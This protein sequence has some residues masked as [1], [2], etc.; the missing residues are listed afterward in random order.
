MTV[1]VENRRRNVG[2]EDPSAYGEN[3]Q[4]DHERCDAFASLEHGRDGATD[5]DDMGDTTYQNAEKDSSDPAD[6][7][8]GKP[9]A[10]DWDDIRKEAISHVNRCLARVSRR[11]GMLT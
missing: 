4:R 6:L 10:E 5:H 8:V 1:L 2:L 3:E 9:T 11:G 7:G